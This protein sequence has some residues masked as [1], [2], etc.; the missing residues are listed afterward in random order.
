MSEAFNPLDG[1]RIAFQEVGQGTPLVLVH[2]SALSRAIWRG[3][4]Y[5]AALRDEYRLVL[6]DMRGHGL[7]GKP[8]D[9][10]DY[11]MPLVVADVLAVYDAAGIDAAHYFGYSFGARVGFSLADAHPERMLSLTSAGGTYRIGAGAVSSLFF[12]GYDEA[13]RRGGMRGFIDGWEARSGASIDP[14]TT[15]AFLANDPEALRAYFRQL[16]VEQGVDEARLAGILTPTLL[17]AGTDDRPR[18]LDSER[19]ARLMPDARFEPLPGRGHA[20]TLFPAAPVIELL[21]GFLSE[22]P[23]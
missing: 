8:H 14:A 3:F 10:A 5:V 23:R 20:N 2:G 17:L 19:A 22:L 4:G 11:A 7:S 1:T 21:R 18:Y 9:P 6:I 16:Q 15:R 12:E 13:L